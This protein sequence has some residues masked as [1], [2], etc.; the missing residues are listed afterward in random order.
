MIC[1]INKQYT[2]RQYRVLFDSKIDFVSY[3]LSIEY[4]VIDRDYT[5]NI[6]RLSYVT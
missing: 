4:Y 2:L 1:I 3:G 6:G 5:G